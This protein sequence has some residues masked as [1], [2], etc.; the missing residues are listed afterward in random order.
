VRPAPSRP[1][2]CAFRRVRAS[3][4]RVEQR[5][6]SP[7]A[8]RRRE[9]ALARFPPSLL[10][11]LPPFARPPFCLA[12][13]SCAK[14]CACFWLIEQHTESRL[15]GRKSAGGCRTR[16]VFCSRLASERDAT[17]KPSARHAN[18]QRSAKNYIRPNKPIICAAKPSK[19]RANSSV[20]RR[21]TARLFPET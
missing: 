6:A 21:S 16:F 9:H 1:A 10:E 17:N 12:T 5:R 2:E 14:V 13:P 20:L 8:V 3:I 7:E 19:A 11:R 15:P 4:G 18:S